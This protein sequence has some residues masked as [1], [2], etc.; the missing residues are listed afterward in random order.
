VGFGS[1]RNIK[2]QKSISESNIAIF[3]TDSLLQFNNFNSLAIMDYKFINT[4]YLESVAGGDPEIARELVSMFKEQT[5]EIFNDMKSLF[6]AKNYILLG[7]LAHKAKSSVAIMGMNDLA[8]MLKT[9][10][11]QA[12]EGKESQLYESYISRFKTDT[13]TAVIELEDYLMNRIN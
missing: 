11:L 1:L 5:I 10:E 9:F 12:K 8:I 4:E 2:H 7:Q 3:V 6:S 13:D